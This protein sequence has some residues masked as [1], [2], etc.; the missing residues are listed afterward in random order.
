MSRSPARTR[1]GDEG[2]EIELDPPAPSP[3]GAEDITRL[4]IPHHLAPR[5]SSEAT[6]DQPVSPA[7]E[8]GGF[9]FRI[10]ESRFRSDRLGLRRA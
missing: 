7:P 5:L 6:D 9:T 1:L 10:G 4:T 2:I 3:F 8:D